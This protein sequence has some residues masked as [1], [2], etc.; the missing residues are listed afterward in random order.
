MDA[1]AQLITDLRDTDPADRDTKIAAA[2]AT[3]T[4]PATIAEQAN[5]R[6]T[7]LRD[8]ADSTTAV[9]DME[10][11][12]DVYTYATNNAPTPTATEAV[13]VTLPDEAVSGEVVPAPT[14]PFG[15]LAY[16]PP[17]GGSQRPTT[18]LALN[19]DTWTMQAK[20]DAGGVRSGQDV[21]DPV[22]LGTLANDAFN[23]LGELT[24]G[25]DRQVTPIANFRYTGS[26]RAVIGPD[27]TTRQ[28]G[29]ALDNNVDLSKIAFD[30]KTATFG[31]GFCSPSETQY[32]VECPTADL[33]DLWDVPPVVI[34]RGGL[35]YPVVE[36]FGSV[37][38]DGVGCFTEAEEIAR[39]E[40]KPCYLVPCPE[41]EEVRLN[42]CSMCIQA[43]IL[44]QFAY[45]E[46][47]ADA[48]ARRLVAFEHR[49]SANLVA[50]AESI[51]TVVAPVPA[52]G[53]N[54]GP[55][56]A[57]LLFGYL[58]LQATD[59]RYRNRYARN[60]VLDVVMP[61]W[62]L[63]ILRSDVTKRTGW[64]GIVQTDAWINSKFA[65][66]NLRPQ[67]IVDW[68]DAFASGVATDMGGTTPPTAW[69]TRAKILM[70]AP[71]SLQAGRGDI[72]RITGVRNDPQLLRQNVELALFVEVYWAL[73]NRCPEVR[74][75]DIPTCP[76]GQT[77]GSPVDAITCPGI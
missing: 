66:L 9:G 70:Y 2:F 56:F 23:V 50:A 74:L 76:T 65:A 13:T 30:A 54:Y 67:W 34:T 31:T 57:A 64:D 1:L 51:A 25:I 27:M 3:I 61:A 41:F 36:D 40:D 22:A 71:G 8:Y 17:N 60:R 46:W 29:E 44:A 10:I 45:P 39:T 15:A 26:D 73:I 21:T 62:L 42:L 63:G 14:A 53:T 16:T 72:V 19:S 68:Q 33:A 4:D 47:I 24:S 52:D 77:A 20:R 58:D 49:L 69:P 38:G 11:L 32:G 28:I 5:A 12:A 43:P 37:Y 55:G 6:F 35:R 18:T 7:S 75:L 48:V 59:M